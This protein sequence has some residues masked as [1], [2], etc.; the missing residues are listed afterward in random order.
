MSTNESNSG[1]KI[2]KA[3]KSITQKQCR[4]SKFYK[5]KD[6]MTLNFQ[7]LVASDSIIF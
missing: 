3:A 7:N 6:P 2:P 4:Q 5:N 1:L